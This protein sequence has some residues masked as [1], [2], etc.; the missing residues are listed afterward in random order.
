MSNSRRASSLKRFGIL[1]VED[2]LTY[3]PF[4][5]TDPVPRG[6]LRQA[7]VGESIAFRAR[8]AQSRA[9]PLRARSG[10]RLE[11]T[12][13]DSEFTESGPSGV[14]QLVFFSHKRNYVTWMLSKLGEGE[15]VVVCG[16]PTIFNNTLQFTHPDVLV[17]G[18]GRDADTAEQALEK[19][20]KP[21]PVYHA[22]ARFSSE[23]IHESILEVLSALEEQGEG[24]IADIVP[25]SVRESVTDD[26]GHILMTRFD[27]FRAIHRPDSVAQFHRGIH[28]M[29]YEEAFV[30]QISLL[31]TRRNAQKTEAF[32][33]PDVSAQPSSL[34]SRMLAS[35]PF[36]LTQGQE[37]VVSQI[38]QDLAEDHPMQRLLQGEVGSGKTIVALLAMLQVVDAGYQAVL[39]APTQ[40]LAEQHYRKISEQCEQLGGI[41]GTDGA[42][43]VLLLT[44]ALKLVERRRTLALVA[45]GEP[46][47]VIATHS[48]FS[49]SF[50]APR[51]AL[52]IIDEQHRFGVEQRD[53]LTSKSERTPHLLVMTAT[54]IPRT[55]AMTWFGDL[56]IS[57]LKGLP[58]GRK[59]IS[60]FVIPEMDSKLMA[61]MLWHLRK[62]IDAGERAYVVCPAIDEA[63][64]L[65]A[66]GSGE[67]SAGSKASP[68]AATA[69]SDADYVDLFVDDSLDDSETS[70]PKPPLHSVQ[71]IFG[72]FSGLPQFEGI[73]IAT[74]TGRDDEATK[75]RVMKEFADGTTPL[76]VSTT[77]IE[78]GVDVSTASCMVIF[79]ADRFGL[80][81][82]HQLRGRVG[83]GGTQGWAFLVSRAD[84]DSVAAERLEVIRTST[85]G[86]TI[87]E[88]DIELRGVGDVLGDAQSGG[89][90][91]LKLL[92]VVKDA[93]L[94]T[95]ARSDAAK[96]LEAADG[97]LSDQP[98]LGG[99][100]LDFMRGKEKFLT[101]T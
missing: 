3:Y 30:S 82:L 96:V 93:G 27:A 46:C 49:K 66:G 48:A 53:A 24:S 91:S 101:R 59:P 19:V 20:T 52:A 1:T 42:P 22:T 94:I 58:G 86:A 12:V 100:I 79:D 40:V 56:E 65:G 89:K 47:I 77:V 98:Q 4:R 71:E 97:D 45:S 29:R 31:Q 72:R 74:L 13:E 36:E 21:L 10:S 39:V 80:S 88:A 37:S 64:E 69:E 14:A 87:A 34:Q 54:P 92:R 55:A 35:L 23:R 18:A 28:T 25:E 11:V 51:L 44:G 70:E 90:S 8:I 81:Q 78:V 62:R 75:N 50:Q 9:I 57:E 7:K 67:L 6:G 99:A 16:T 32:P 5:V 2:A 76:L 61:T 43:H 73:S 17:I 60:T 85:D 95:R 26:D 68:K 15:E 83:R 38:S 33:C 41:L 63:S 84:P